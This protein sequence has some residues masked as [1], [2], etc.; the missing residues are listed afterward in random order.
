MWVNQEFRR[1]FEFN[2]SVRF[3]DIEMN[4][5]FC[6][7]QEWIRENVITENFILWG[8]GRIKI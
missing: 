5:L 8:E 2:N 6:L 3:V 4:F 7:N 1:I